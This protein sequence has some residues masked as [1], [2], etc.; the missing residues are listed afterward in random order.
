MA[1]P[2]LIILKHLSS[3]K[4]TITLLVLIVVASIIGTIIPQTWTDEQYK[5]KYGDSLS[6]MLTGTQLTNVYHSY[7]YMLLLVVF[8]VNLTICSI[9]SFVPMLKSL[10]RSASTA[11]RVEL[12]SLPFHR[13]VQLNTDAEDAGSQV[14]QILTR[15]L[16][17]LK[18]SDVNSG[19][20]YFERGKLGRLG[21]LITHASIIVILVGGIF[22]G[23]LG[24]KEH[25][26][27]TVGETV[28]VPRS[29][30][31]LRADD[32][33]VEYYPESR[34]PKEYTSVLTVIEDDEP[35]L[36]K[37]IE[38]NH[39]LEY[40]GVK[41]YQS[42]YGLSN[43]VEVELSKKPSDEASEVL[44][45]F[46]LNV[47]E[48]FQVTDSQL[49]IKPVVLVPDFFMDSSG[50]VGTRSRE[51]KNPAVFLELY[52][53]EELKDKI[54]AFLKFPDFHGSGE[55][56]YSLKFLDIKYYTEL[57][58]SQDPGIL[59]IWIGSLL[60]VGGLFLSFY[61]SYKR[62]W[63][64][65]SASKGGTVVEIGGRSYR[66]RSGFDRE[67]HQLEASLSH[68]IGK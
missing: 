30:F 22:V 62:I 6:R 11:G 66:D 61:M 63:V 35:Q 28:D 52:E 31:Q 56:G 21:P 68:S 26:R 60:M 2:D 16:Y 55:S 46:S 24:F 36:T 33:K 49:K 39:P 13:K 3:V 59:A 67:F 8:C 20:Y 32:F 17:K 10:T 64:K 7:W 47:G 45:K 65:L 27:I 4:L 18:Y 43:T 48:L 53:G 42:S 29:D 23:L 54:W 40:K 1:F 58:V 12:D 38:V 15:S 9:R 34:T 37:T 41:F 57:Q 5:A 19:L 50:H 14:K 44:G 51:P 25:K